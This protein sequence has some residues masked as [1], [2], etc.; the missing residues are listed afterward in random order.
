MLYCRDV[1]RTIEVNDF[2]GRKLAL[3]RLGDAVQSPVYVF[4][5]ASGTGPLFVIWDTDAANA[6]VTSFSLFGAGTLGGE[7]LLTG[8]TVSS[9]D[10]SAGVT[11]GMCLGGDRAFLSSFKVVVSAINQPTLAIQ[12]Y[13]ELGR[14]PVSKGPT[15]F[16][17]GKAPA[18]AAEFLKYIVDR[19]K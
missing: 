15:Y 18:I 10:T 17:V 9:G 16:V 14:F 5:T 6:V 19:Q 4:M 12:S 11:S 1:P 13:V 7:D 8:G 2:D 3:Q